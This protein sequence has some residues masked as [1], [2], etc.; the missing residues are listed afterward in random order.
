MVTHF[1]IPKWLVS[2]IQRSGKSPIL[3]NQE[4]KPDQQKKVL[5][6]SG[7]PVTAGSPVSAEVYLFPQDHLL[8]EESVDEILMEYIFG[9]VIGQNPKDGTKIQLNLS[10]SPEGDLIGRVIC[11]CEVEYSSAKCSLHNE[12][13]MTL[14]SE[15]HLGE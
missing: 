9:N 13:R 15:N 2:V 4:Q 14:R 1:A 10:L 8:S 12:L 7:A 5:L 6:D 3:Q 11:F